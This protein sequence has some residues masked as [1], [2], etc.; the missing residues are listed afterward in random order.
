M[1]L[2]LIFSSLLECDGFRFISIDLSDSEEI[3]YSVRL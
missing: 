3:V 1:L 2:D